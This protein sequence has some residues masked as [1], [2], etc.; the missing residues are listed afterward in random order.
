[1][2]TSKY[3]SSENFV[4][5]LAQEKGTGENGATAWQGSKYDPAAALL[6]KTMNVYWNLDL[7][8]WESSTLWKNV[9]QKM[10]TLSFDF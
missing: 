5:S 2:L 7:S 4:L 10:N 1:M 8:L 3:I 6:E 9:R